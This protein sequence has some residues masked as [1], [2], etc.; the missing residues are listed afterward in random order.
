MGG[1]QLVAKR[2]GTGYS[3]KVRQGYRHTTTLRKNSGEIYDKC[4]HRSFQV[5]LRIKQYIFKSH[6]GA[7]CTYAET[8]QGRWSYLGECLGTFSTFKPGKVAE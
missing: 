1:F 3:L 4:R 2:R 6:P 8:V 5:L 7:N